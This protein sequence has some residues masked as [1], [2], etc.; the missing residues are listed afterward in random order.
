MPLMIIVRFLLS[1]V[2]LAILA[3][4]V[5]LLA[6][7]YDGTIYMLE[8]DGEMVRHRELWM[9]LVGAAL[10]AF[11]LVAASS[12]CRCSPRAIRTR[13]SLSAAMA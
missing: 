7:W 3:G 6:E 4:S 8:N 11:S 12:W 1:L 2:S 5:Y 9:L 10:L 13:P